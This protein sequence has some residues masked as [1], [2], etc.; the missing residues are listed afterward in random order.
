[1]GAEDVCAATCLVPPRALRVEHPPHWYRSATE[2]TR[3][4]G[5]IL[6]RNTVNEYELGD[7]G[8]RQTVSA[9]DENLPLMSVIN[10][11]PPESLFVTEREPGRDGRSRD[12]WPCQDRVSLGPAREGAPCRLVASLLG[13][14]GAGQ[15]GLG[16]AKSPGGPGD[17]S[18]FW[19]LLPCAQ[20]ALP[21]VSPGRE[22]NLVPFS[23]LEALLWIKIWSN[24]GKSQ[25]EQLLC[26][27]R[28][29]K[30]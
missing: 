27:R 17:S 3:G 1:M 28:P 22:P 21:S 9:S 25:S 5:E 20:P 8:A 6:I 23:V 4:P 18:A 14:E 24:D 29:A 16:L 19:H 11:N 7:T 2:D 10:K 30:A 15:P 13:T 26:T 12:I